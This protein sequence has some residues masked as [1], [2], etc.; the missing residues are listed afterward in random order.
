MNRS[1]SFTASAALAFLS[2]GT[3]AHAELIYGVTD[4]GNLVTFDS[5]T[6]G[7]LNTVGA[8]SG[9][10]EG[11]TFS[12]FRDMDFRPAT[13]QLFALG[14]SGT[15]AQLYTIN[16]ATAA[17]TAVGSGFGLISSDD[18]LSIDFNPSV[19]RL[20]IVA[21]DGSNYRANP[22]TGGLAASPSDTALTYNAGVGTG[23]PTVA[24]IA[25]SNNVP[26]G[27]PTTLYGFDLKY[28]SDDT[29]HVRTIGGVNGNP[30]PNGGVVFDVGSTDDEFG[31]TDSPIG[32]D[33]SGTTGVAYLS[34]EPFTQFA[35]NPSLFTVN[36]GTGNFS[37]VGFFNSNVVSL[38]V[39]AAAP[40]AVPEP[41]SIALLAGIGAA[42]LL[43][44]RRRRK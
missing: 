31:F 3:V 30:T 5:A 33:I 10:V 22:I 4:T 23:K 36:L 7:A 1:V 12:S 16:T 35:V 43:T 34:A 8:L 2:L 27:T 6:P 15:S 42:G 38:A 20:R 37:P 9:F 18:S 40:G 29:Q 14:T 32:F 13:G 21:R 24:S 19:D 39:F 17:L 41:G 44:L 26:G 11:Q 28:T 25:Y